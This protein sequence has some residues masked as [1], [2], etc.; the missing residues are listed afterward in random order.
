MSDE[1]YKPG[2]ITPDSGQYQVVGPRGGDRG[3][4]E[5]TS[6]EGNP[7]PPT[8]QPDLRYKLVDKTK[9]KNK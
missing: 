8:S 2:E 6:V 4:Q 3:G 5:V 9:H 7:L 1:L